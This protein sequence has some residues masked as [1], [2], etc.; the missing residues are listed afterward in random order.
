M[1]DIH[2][3]ADEAEVIIDGYAFTPCDNEIRVLN[4]NAPDKAAVY[5]RDGSVLETTM[6][7]IELHIVGKH[8]QV[9]RKYMEE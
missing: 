5:G 6:D 3:I 2:K 7:D 8:L 9:A 4:L 1:L